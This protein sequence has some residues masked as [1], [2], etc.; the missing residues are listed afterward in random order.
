MA[1]LLIREGDAVVYVGLTSGIIKGCPI[2]FNCLTLIIF[3]LDLVQ[4]IQMK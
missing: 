3:T 2:H 4:Y 1:G